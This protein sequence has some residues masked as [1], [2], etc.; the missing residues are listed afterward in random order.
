MSTTS[1][2]ND[3]RLTHGIDNEPTQMADVYLVLSDED[4][5]KGFIRPVRQADGSRCRP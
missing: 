4:R 3:P 1:D 2:R 5:A